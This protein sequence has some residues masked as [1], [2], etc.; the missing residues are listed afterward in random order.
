MSKQIKVSI[1]VPV[2]NAEDTLEK[3][4]DSL[5]SQTLE[6]IEIVLINDGSTDNSQKIID[7]YS[8][9]FPDKV[10]VIIQDN[11]G[12]G[13][14]RNEGLKIC[15]G[16]YI[17]FLD[18]D[19]Y[20][21]PAMYQI[22]YET[23]IREDADMVMCDY[24]DVHDGVTKVIRV[25]D[26]EKTKQLLID[27]KA[28]P[29]NKLYLSA[30]IKESGVTFREGLIYE[31][32]AF[33]AN[34]VPYIR[35]CINVHEP[36]VYHINWS[37]S[38]TGHA[39]VG[40]YIQMFDILDGILEFYQQNSLWDEY[41]EELEYFYSKILLGSSFLRFASLRN[42]KERKQY[43][44]ESLKKVKMAFP[45]FRSNIYYKGS[46]M[47]FYIRMMNEKSVILIGKLMNIVNK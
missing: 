27:P 32:T 12:Q 26:V 1:V 39:D 3:C 31:D 9:N 38:T 16:M 7:K 22:M 17:G 19:D 35:K 23:A 18:S 42:S 34:M 10:R 21:D 28:A 41:H 24:F 43:L 4:V 20:V 37:G 6:E 13:K 47:Q 36:F 5:L 46:K 45:N 8:L 25:K 15:Q 29:W 40:R 44:R 14:A 33:Y 2:Y 30:R 11:G